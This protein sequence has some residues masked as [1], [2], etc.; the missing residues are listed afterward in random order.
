VQSV[1]VQRGQLCAWPTTGFRA[2]LIACL[3]AHVRWQSSTRCDAAS[4][5][6]MLVNNNSSNTPQR[7]AGDCVHNVAAPCA[8]RRAHCCA[9]CGA[10][11]HCQSGAPGMP[12]H[13]G[14]NLRPKATKQHNKSLLT[15][16][17][18]SRRALHHRC[19]CIACYCVPCCGLTSSPR[20]T[21]S[22][23]GLVSASKSNC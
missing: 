5:A 19:E 7:D 11:G 15:R 20:T 1:V 6:A 13:T 21:R 9:H 4:A 12:A 16:L 23:R 2:Q 17:R 8:L 3:T 10:H 22:K 14:E 18:S